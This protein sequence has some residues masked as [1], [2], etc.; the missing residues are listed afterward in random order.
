MQTADPVHELA[1]LVRSRHGLALL[2]IEDDDRAETLLRHLADRFA[3]PYFRWSRTTGLVRDGTDG[4]VYGTR[5]PAAALAHVQH[6]AFPAVYHFAGLAPFLTDATTTAALSDAIRPYESNDGIL[7]LT[8]SDIELPEPVRMRAGAIRMAPPGAADYHELLGRIIR[9]VRTRQSVDVE[10]DTRALKRL[11]A[12]LRGLTLLEAEKLLTRAVVEDG[13]LSVDDIQ[14]VLEHKR[15]VVEREGLLEYYPAEE[16]MADIA[17]LVSLKD[18]LA[19]RRSIITEPDRAREFG[20]EFP[21]GV[22]LVGVPGSGKSLCAKAVATEWTLPLLKLDPARLYNKYVGETEKNF[23]RAMETA[24]RMAPVILWIDE[25]EKAFAEG[26]SEDGGVSTRVLGTFLS[27]LQ[28]RAGDVFVVATANAVEKLPPELLRKGRFDEVFFVDLPDRDAR[29]AIFRI[30]LDRRGQDPG[31]FDLDALAAATD[32]FS[33]AEVEQVVVS[34]LYAAFA[35]RAELSDAGLIAEARA[36]RPLSVVAAERIA[37]LRGW[38]E[39]RT[40]RAN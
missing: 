37:A 23:R 3:I 18:W 12:N 4:P 10:I 14:A 9:D 35:D 34:A 30:H 32:G 25:I 24:E 39:G 1:L 31:A 13:R 5:E 15:Q 7:I 28:E 8:G 26:G 22:L 6:A 16:A 17:D 2:E 21:R 36:T 20:L 33:G 29:G 19:R 11:Y 27:W 38:A 40:V